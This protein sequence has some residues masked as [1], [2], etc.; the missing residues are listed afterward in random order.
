MIPRKLALDVDR[1]LPPPIL[2]GDIN[3]G[4]GGNA[5]ARVVHQDVKTPEQVYDPTGNRRPVSFRGDI[6]GERHRLASRRPDGV[7]DRTRIDNV[8]D[9]N[10][11]PLMCRRLGYAATQAVRP[12]TGALI[13]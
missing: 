1:E 2:D 10:S 4:S 6:E 8:G 9:D 3:D 7:Y 11:G 5:Q 13:C 12:T